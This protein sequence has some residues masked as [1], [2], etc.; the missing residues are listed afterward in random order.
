MSINL[1]ET[2]ELVVRGTYIPTPL[3]GIEQ[4]DNIN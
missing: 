4:L 3:P 1:T 2:K